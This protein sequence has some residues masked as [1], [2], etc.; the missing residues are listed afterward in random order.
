M[1]ST[2]RILSSVR[3]ARPALAANVTRQT[4]GYASAAA[5]GGPNYGLILS[6]AGLTGIGAY[7]YLQ[8]NPAAKAEISAK[9]HELEAKA[10][11][12]VRGVQS[13]VDAANQGTGSFGALIKDTWTP[14]TLTNIEPYNHNT[15]IYT[16]SFGDDSQHKVSGGQVASALLVKSPGGD[17]EVKD[18][19]GK[20]VIRPYTPVSSTE[21]KGSIDLMIKEYPTGKLTPYISSMKPG[22]QLL[23]KGPIVKYKYE[24]NTFDRGLAVAGGSGIT[25][26][27]Q[28]ISHSLNIP[29]DKTKWTLVFS[30]VTE[31]DILLRKEWDELAKQN[32]DRLD[33]KYVLDKGPWG[34]KGETGFVTPAMLSKLFPRSANSGERIKAF[35]CGPPPQVKSLAGPKDGP[36]QGELQGAF[37]ELGYAADEV[38]KF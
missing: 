2:A 1:A 35:V 13:E 10:E 23:F 7:A 9:A 28:L 33:V 4:R 21:Q 8:Y 12:K 26:M 19:K 25:P 38:F 14:F 36:R 18:D 22:Q 16:F 3:I 30:N 20:P 15:A 32:P 17:D 29:E 6:L 37:K 27:Y 5:G 11:K 34:W 24:P 31:K